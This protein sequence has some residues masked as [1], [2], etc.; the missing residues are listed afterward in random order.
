MAMRTYLTAFLATAVVFLGLDFLWL[1]QVAAGF[2]RDMLGGHLAENPDFA[3]AGL[4]YG[5]Y[6]SGIMYFAVVP[7]I[8]RG[9]LASALFS[10]GLFGFVAY[11]T[12][13]LTNMATL[14]DWPAML[15]VVDLTWGTFV[16]AVASAAGYGLSMRLSPAPST[17]HQKGMRSL[18]RSLR[19]SIPGW[20]SSRLRS[21]VSRN[22]RSRSRNSTRE[23]A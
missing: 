20:I 5:I 7:A 17:G 6:L 15:T 4:F 21:S 2:Y 10:G 23:E 18:E 1:S 13:D 14:K 11:A 3:A 19:G 16:T 12:Y 9:T 8:A 22:R